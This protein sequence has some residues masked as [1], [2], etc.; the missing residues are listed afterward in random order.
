MSAAIVACTS[1][2][3][4]WQPDATLTRH[5]AIIDAARQGRQ[6]P[7]T[8]LQDSDLHWDDAH[9]FKDGRGNWL[10]WVYYVDPN[11]GKRW[12]W[13]ELDDQLQIVAMGGS[14]SG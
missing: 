13:I 1:P 12:T 4:Q 6:H 11:R 7:V 9:V 3:S 2:S 14:S 5:R 10:V 8:V